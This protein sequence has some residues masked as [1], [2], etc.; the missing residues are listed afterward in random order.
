MNPK[1]QIPPDEEERKK[2]ERT[3]IVIYIIMAIFIILPFVFLLT[4]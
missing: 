1:N 3:K 4:R 2:A